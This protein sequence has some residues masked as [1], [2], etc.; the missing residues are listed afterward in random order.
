M[1]RISEHLGRVSNCR[2][3]ADIASSHI[4][5][6]VI[7][8]IYHLPNEVCCQSDHSVLDDLAFSKELA[9]KTYNFGLKIIISASIKELGNS[10]WPYVIE[11]RLVNPNVIDYNE[12]SICVSR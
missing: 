8:D 2:Y 12:K 9:N 6:N 7:Y 11:I 5:K 10:Q 3:I 1:K 4:A